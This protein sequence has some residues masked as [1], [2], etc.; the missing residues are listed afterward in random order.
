MRAKRVRRVGLLGGSF[1][2]PHAGHLR[3]AKIS[4]KRL[5]LDEVIWLPCGQSAYG[6]RLSPGASRLR[7]LRA[8]LRGQR[9]MRASAL[10]LKQRG[11]ARTYLTLRR[12]RKTL[13]GDHQYFWI[14]GQDQ[15]RGFPRWKRPAE[16][17]AACQVIVFPRK[18]RQFSLAENR[19]LKKFGMRKIQVS[20]YEISSSSIRKAQKALNK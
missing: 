20:I 10:D 9:K 11:P 2:P 15:L 14:M 5:K 7:Q 16:V 13:G 3:L 8:F 12:V 19:I 1:D 4:L 18:S 6:K 17:A